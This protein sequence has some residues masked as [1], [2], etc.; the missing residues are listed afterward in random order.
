MIVDLAVDLRIPTMITLGAALVLFASL[1]IVL[2]IPLR[3]FFPF[4]FAQLDSALHRNDDESSPAINLSV[5]FPYFDKN[6]R[7]VY[8]SYSYMVVVRL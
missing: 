6:Y 5:I 3:D 4:G 8:V 1:R 7:V 2:C